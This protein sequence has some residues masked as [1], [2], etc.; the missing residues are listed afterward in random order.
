MRRLAVFLFWTIVFIA[1][2]V[3]TDQLLLRVEMPLPVLAEVRTFYVDF[4]GR[5]LQLREA[6][7][8]GRPASR[9]AAPPSPA[10]APVRPPQPP[11]ATKKGA[12]ASSAETPSP[13]Y[14]YVDRGGELR[15]ADSLEEVPAAYREE[16]Q[17]LER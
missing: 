12:P 5:L 13:R 3:G 14:L 7:P 1:L 17:R 16:A 6:P 9:P 4:R 2:A 10:A 15:F 8:K 11:P